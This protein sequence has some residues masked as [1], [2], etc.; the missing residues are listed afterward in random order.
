MNAGRSGPTTCTRAG[1]RTQKNL[2]ADAEAAQRQPDRAG[3]LGGSPGEVAGWRAAAEA[4]LLPYDQELGV[5][6]QADGFTGHQRWD[7]A[8]TGADQYPLLLHFPYFELY[9]KQVVKQAALVLAMQLRP[10]AF[11][12]EQKARNFAYYGGAY[13]AGLLAVSVQPGRAG[14]R[15]RP[16]GPGLRLPGR[17]GPD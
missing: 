7:F 14:R 17:G 2:A 16:P 4:M 8:A 10:D 3:E 15:G 13:G 11:R 6:P 9:R 5:H 12:G 1:W